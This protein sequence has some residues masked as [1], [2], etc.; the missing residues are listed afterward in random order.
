MND[1]KHQQLVGRL[2]PLLFLVGG[3]IF[4]G[5]GA[6]IYLDEKQA[7]EVSRPTEAEI[8]ASRVVV[9]ESDDE[10]SYY[11]DITYRYEHEGQHY[12]SS[13]LTPGFG[14]TSRSQSWAE[15]LVEEHPP[16]AV[17]TAYVNPGEPTEAF[18]LQESSWVVCFIAMGVG[19]ILIVLAVRQGIRARRS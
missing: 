10:I 5:T 4:A 2:S 1:T 14:N 12:E 17:V 3:L 11:P 8:I 9:E 19:A 7:I 6:F 15:T 13:N 18:L 16:G